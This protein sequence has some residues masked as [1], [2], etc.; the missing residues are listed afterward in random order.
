MAVEIRYVKVRL[1]IIHQVRTINHTFLAIHK[2]G[3]LTA[4]VV[5]LPLHRRRK[6]DRELRNVVLE[7][8]RTNFGLQRSL[9]Q[10]F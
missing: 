2:K 8:M 9:K 1:F 10:T 3:H 4:G 6:S 7:V 5:S